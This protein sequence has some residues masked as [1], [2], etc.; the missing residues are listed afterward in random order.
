MLNLSIFGTRRVM[1]T[2]SKKS[3]KRLTDQYER[4][5][6][7]VTECELSNLKKKW[8]Y[9]SDCP[10]SQYNELPFTATLTTQQLFTPTKKDQKK[11][12]KCSV[13]PQIFFNIQKS[14]EK[15]TSK[16]ITPICNLQANWERKVDVLE[17]TM[18][19]KF[20]QILCCS[21]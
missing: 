18:P 8:L 20:R 1:R 11:K 9:V 13:G 15:Q 12:V 4:N 16:L 19:S 7:W 6:S 17:I 5:T 21:F 14:K 2:G 3:T 10:S